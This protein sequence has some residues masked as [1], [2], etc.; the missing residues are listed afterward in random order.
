M[1][2]L[3]EQEVRTK[4]SAI[5]LEV[6]QELESKTSQ[7]RFLVRC[8]CGE[9][10]G[11][12]LLNLQRSSGMCKKCYHQSRITPPEHK[13]EL[14][15]KN[16][17]TEKVRASEQAYR[18]RPEVKERALSYN[19]S[20]QGKLA[21]KRYISKPGPAMAHALRRRF[22]MAIRGGAKG[23]SAVRDLGCTV[24]EFRSLIEALWRPGMTWE[25]W[26][27]GPGTW[28]V[29][30]IRPLASFDLSDPAQVRAACHFTN[31][32]PLWHEDHIRKSLEDK[33]CS[34]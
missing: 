29:D 7:R 1:R 2:R 26:G 9:V 24:A 32:Q 18:Q 19:K 3:S 33:K 10:W 17:R 15:K 22:G 34:Q 25:N 8:S 21:Q 23:G 12:Y 5:G 13:R 27:K 16:R 20:A 6:V 31:L 14:R 28:Q 30:H 11:G 4:L